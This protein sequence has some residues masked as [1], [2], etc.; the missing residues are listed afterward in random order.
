MVSNQV[1][2][3]WVVIRSTVI[4]HVMHHIIS[5]FYSLHT[6]V[7]LACPILTHSYCIRVLL[8]HVWQSLVV[9]IHLEWN[10]I[11]MYLHYILFCMS[12]PNTHGRLSFSFPF[13]FVTFLTLSIHNDDDSKS[14]SLL[15]QEGIF[16]VYFTD[17]S[18][19]YI[20]RSFKSSTS[21]QPEYAFTFYLTRLNWSYLMK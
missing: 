3:V 1:I 5:C 21:K 15:S 2:F 16:S 18:S 12:I 11:C 7:K 17:S 19:K 8:C 10:V 6:H 4:C 9:P 20:P 14:K 13:L